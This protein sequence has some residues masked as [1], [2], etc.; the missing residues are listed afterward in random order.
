MFDDEGIPKL[1]AELSHIDDQLSRDPI[2]LER[3]LVC[4]SDADET[5]P[6]TVVLAEGDSTTKGNV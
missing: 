1:R 2:E 3:R 5:E 4:D 6:S